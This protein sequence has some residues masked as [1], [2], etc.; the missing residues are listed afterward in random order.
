MNGTLLTWNGS[1]SWKLFNW[2]SQSPSKGRCISHGLPSTIDNAE[3]STS[4]SDKSEKGYNLCR[5]HV[6]L[7]ER[8]MLKLVLNVKYLLL[9][10]FLT[11]ANFYILGHIQGIIRVHYFLIWFLC[12]LFKKINTL[13][14]L[15][16]PDISR[17]SNTKNTKVLSRLI[18]S[19]FTSNCKKKV[20]N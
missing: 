14:K 10:F 12:W 11:A 7:T 16:E 3:C 6:I 13:S 20:V 18:L 15:H 17:Y 19:N 9:L 5:V 8:R 4:V 2:S 1:K